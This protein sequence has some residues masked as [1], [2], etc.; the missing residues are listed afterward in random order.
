MA[1][2]TMSVCAKAGLLAL[3]LTLGLASPVGAEGPKKKTPAV[4]K[5]VAKTPSK[6]K[7]KPTGDKGT[8]PVEKREGT[9][10][11]APPKT[12]AP[13]V[14]PAKAK[15]AKEKARKEAL[16][17]EAGKYYT[18]GLQLYK[19]DLYSQAIKAFQKSYD[20]YPMLI[21]I[22]NIAKSYERL[23]VAESCIEWFERYVK[24]YRKE[25]KKDPNDINDIK[26]AM[27]KCRLGLR[28][29]ITFE[30]EPTGASVY[31][32]GDD[33][34]VGQTTLKT[35]LQPGTHKVLIKFPGYVPVRRKIV[36]RK[37]ESRKLFFKLE[38]VMRSGTLK[39][40]SNIRGASIFVDGRNVGRTPFS[41]AI[42]IKEGRHQVTVE[43]EDYVPVTKTI[44]VLA[45][46]KYEVDAS[47]WLKNPPGTWKKPVGWT[48]L[49]FGALL[50]TGGFAAGYY[51]DNYRIFQGTEDF[52]L[53]T[54]LQKVGYIGGGVLAGSGLILLI[55]EA[56]GQGRAI[57]PKD[58]LSGHEKRP[59][60]QVTPLLSVHQT[61]GSLGAHV[62]F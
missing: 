56:V 40:N 45:K 53:Y 18:E 49:T 15:A 33:A 41:Q 60:F 28:L 22:Y 21:T 27:S 36:V 59:R 55:W 5:K 20:I 1:E 48:S 16:I 6:E 12:E 61:G 34:L 23:G 26:N 3:M 9:Q 54:M 7:K 37:G 32:D 19:K 2:G 13:P 52:K 8:V 29:E 50:I 51:V 17:E 57:K 47:L 43:K 24:R 14:D 4:T 35:K 44:Q 62:R 38:K 58:A 42:V 30:S 25:N 11:Q 39:V 46:Q 31:I 10:P